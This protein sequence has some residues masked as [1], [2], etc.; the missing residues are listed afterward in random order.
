MNREPA[1]LLNRQAN[2][3]P[4]D[5]EAYVIKAFYPPLAADHLF[6]SLH[7]TLAWREESI[8]VFGK[9]CRVPRLTC[10]YGDAD[11]VYRYSGVRHEPL[12]WHPALRAIKLRIEACCGATFNSVLANLYR[13]GRDSMGYHADDEKALGEHP[14]IASLSLGDARLF[15]LRHKKRRAN[16]DIVLEHGDLLI[17]AGALQHHW[18]HAVPKTRQT[19]KPRINL[20][21]RNI[22]PMSLQSCHST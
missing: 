8:V 10:W 19:K 18:L 6:A 7:Q 12:S 9:A 17:M 13:D 3:C 22:V 11:A 2:L 16:L 5:G 14:L 20:T 21:F 1:V 15:K 4:H